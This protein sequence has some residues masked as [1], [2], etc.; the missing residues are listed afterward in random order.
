MRK[1]LAFLILL[2][3]TAGFLYVTTLHFHGLNSV[4]DLIAI[5]NGLPGM[6]QLP[7]TG[8]ETVESPEGTATVAV[9]SL[10]IPHIFGA[11]DNAVAYAAGYM[12][13]RDRYFQ[14][15]LVA[16][17][18][19]GR[20]AE[21]V[22][23][24]GA[25]SDQ[26]W[27]RFD[28]EKKAVRIMDSLSRSEPGLYQY[29]QAYSRG[30]ND[31]L[32]HESDRLRDPLFLIWDWSPKR[33]EPYYSLLI[34]WYISFDLTFY[35]DYFDRQEVL[36]KLPKNIRDIVY[37]DRKGGQPLI[38]PAERR[39]PFPHGLSVAHAGYFGQGQ[40]NTY[41]SRPT[42]RSLGSNN[43]ILG[44]PLTASGDLFLCNDLHLA[45]TS[46]NIFYEMELHSPSL[47]AYGYS[48]PGVPVILTGHNEKI[49]W[50]VTNGGWDV[51]EQYVL[52][53]DSA[54]KDM[55]W[56]DGK[57]Q[58]MEDRHFSILMKGRG[59]M[60][61]DVQYTVFGPVVR[62]GSF[63][64][65]LHW[66][67]ADWTS[68]VQS[69]W[70]LNRAGDW[71]QFRSALSVYDYPAQNF[72]FG[73][74][75]G[76][77]GMV[78]AGKM[79]V[80][81]AGYE[82]GVLEGT[83]SPTWKYIPFDSLPQCYDPAQ[84]YLFSANQQ[85]EEGRYYYSFRWFDDLYRPQRIDDLLSGANKLDFQDMRKM[86][87]DITDLSVKDLQALI[88]KYDPSGGPGPHWDAMLKWDGRLEAE[89]REAAVFKAFRHSA[90]QCAADM[91]GFL[92]VKSTPSFGQ[93]MQFLA[94]GDTLTYHNRTLSGKE[95]FQR[96]LARADSLYAAD[97]LTGAGPGGTAYSFS[98]P[99]MTYLPGF[100]VRV[101]DVGGSDNTIDVNYQ[102]HAVIRTVVKLSKEGI[103]SW[104]I[105]ATGQTGRL[106][107]KGYWQELV[108]WK[109]NDLHPTQFVSDAGQ[110][111][112]ITQ[113]ISF[114][115][116]Q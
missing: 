73:D 100:D 66:H 70:K 32:G 43:W 41:L 79:P 105:N 68:A 64:Y 2:I 87:L 52:K 5:R 112:G 72:V 3:I 4:Q 39:V 16:Y 9:D 29:L 19:M 76:N 74:T 107:E 48:I 11:N 17:S 110:L 13:A 113:R 45:L 85:P 36:D 63:V 91:A 27:R 103:S 10:G 18:V 23:E 35:D 21:I 28:L 108:P 44:G 25:W 38:I 98:I 83:M 62:R 115:P 80:K 55:Y 106:N 65:A 104:M 88:R 101:D 22:G 95:C 8:T 93:L 26:N 24:D 86:Q 6:H 94:D 40:P 47:H 111:T 59:S 42:N 15:Q 97:S 82:G 14:M 57:W 61:Y 71:D 60:D 78:C 84:H 46:P 99:Q 33:W 114:L 89:S 1:Y 56:L 58:K 53:T 102:A 12:Q 90:S 92:G 34:Q 77:M 81:P 7:A 50:G 96:I 116:H 75:R 37:P 49:A 30:V 51:T 67:P 69:F 109:R 20:L 54:K 31:Y